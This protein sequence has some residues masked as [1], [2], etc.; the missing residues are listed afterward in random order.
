METAFIPEPDDP[1]VPDPGPSPMDVRTR[2]KITTAAWPEQKGDH[3]DAVAMVSI[4]YA[5]ARAFDSY[6]F[7]SMQLA[8]HHDKTWGQAESGS[9]SDSKL[10][11]HCSLRHPYRGPKWLEDMFG[12]SFFADVANVDLHGTPADDASLQGFESLA[13]LHFLD[14]ANTRISDEGLHFIESLSE[15]DS[16]NLANTG[17]SD[18]G[19]KHLRGLRKLTFLFL[20][21]TRIS[22]V[23]MASIGEMKDLGELN[24]GATGVTDKGLKHIEGLQHL[25]VLGLYKTKVSDAGMESVRNCVALPL[26]IST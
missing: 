16:L 6:V 18:A 24:L 5:D 2:R 11:G 21:R 1:A 23:G 3:H 14:L 19:I 7:A 25:G 26:S 4:S 9:R 8:G 10:R 13:E 12:K 15:L 17:I 22:D 20:S